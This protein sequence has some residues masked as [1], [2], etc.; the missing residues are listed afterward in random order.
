MRGGRRR[1][2]R[3]SST[4]AASA[5][6]SGA[7]RLGSAHLGESRNV[8]A[9]LRPQSSGLVHPSGAICQPRQCAG[10]V[11]TALDCQKDVSA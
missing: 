7:T 10:L 6:G 4:C 9:P 11:A 5:A 3:R 2:R 8:R 1:R